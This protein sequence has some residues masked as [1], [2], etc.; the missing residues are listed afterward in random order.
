M[1]WQG[2]IAA[3]SRAAHWGRQVVD[4]GGRGVVAVLRRGWG[5]EGDGEPQA[6]WTLGARILGN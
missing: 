5:E 4:R 2:V 1:D 6:K 3:G